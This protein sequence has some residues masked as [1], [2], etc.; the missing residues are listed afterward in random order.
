MNIKS[1]VNN[2]QNIEPNKRTESA[3]QVKSEQ[4]TD[5]DA[6][7][8]REPQEEPEKRHLSDE[9]LKEALDALKKIPGV[10]QNN[11]RVRVVDRGATRVIFLE[12]SLGTVIRRMTEAELWSLTQQ[13]DATKATGQIYNKAM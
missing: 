11:L 9:E 8:R 12:D 13:R 6:D 2:I 1:V 10:Q 3:N 4:T 5:R 7:G